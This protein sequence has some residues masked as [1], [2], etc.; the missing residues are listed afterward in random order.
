L[1]ARFE[2]CRGLGIKLT[3]TVFTSIPAQKIAERCGFE[4]KIKVLY[5]DI[6]DKNGLPYFPNIPSTN[7]VDFMIKIIDN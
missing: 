2:L 4:T 3:K 7:H 1:Q 6:K 5:G